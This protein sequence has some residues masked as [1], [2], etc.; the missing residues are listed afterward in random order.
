MR[1]TKHSA[2]KL[3]VQSDC[4]MTAGR[5]AVSR[6]L[7]ISAE[8]GAREQLKL[9]REETCLYFKRL[10]N[11][12]VQMRFALYPIRNRPLRHPLS[13]RFR[14]SEGLIL[15]ILLQTIKIAG[16]RPPRYGKR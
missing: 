2:L 7:P 15:L 14:R 1:G 4:V 10:G 6:Q 13:R 5:G 16:D 9:A 8:N 3:L 11:Y 12:R